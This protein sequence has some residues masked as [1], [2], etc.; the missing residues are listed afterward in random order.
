M[1]IVKEKFS[2]LELKLGNEKAGIMYGLIWAICY[3]LASSY[4]KYNHY[5]FGPFQILIWRG[6]LTMIFCGSIISINKDSL[7]FKKPGRFYLV[8]FRS[9]LTG[10][11]QSVIYFIMSKLPLSLIYIINCT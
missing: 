6:F 1:K 5:H 11:Y 8:I 9:F 3:F 4:N 10:Q 7:S 2:S